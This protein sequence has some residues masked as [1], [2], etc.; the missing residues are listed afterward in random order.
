MLE[1]AQP[2]PPTVADFLTVLRGAID[3]QAAAGAS[4]K[5]FGQMFK[6]KAVAGK[7]K[8]SVGVH[9]CSIRLALE[10]EV[11][12]NAMG[13]T[14]DS[15]DTWFADL[16][17]FTLEPGCLFEDT[18]KQQECIQ[19]RKTLCG[20][21]A[22]FRTYKP[23]SF[24]TYINELG[25]VYNDNDAEHHFVTSSQSRFPQTNDLLAACVA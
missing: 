10:F 25:K 6:D 15:L 11:V 23:G 16:A 7:P 19:Q 1:A 18:A 22:K 14:N 8:G 4:A 3:P 12:R 21:L 24:R 20:N 13:E 17:C 5:L 2:A 9:K